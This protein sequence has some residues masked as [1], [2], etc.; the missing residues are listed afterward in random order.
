[1][2]LELDMLAYDRFELSFILKVLRCFGFPAKWIGWI[3][4]GVSTV[5]YLVLLNDSAYGWF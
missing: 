1:M 4:L 3:K 5:S 2:V